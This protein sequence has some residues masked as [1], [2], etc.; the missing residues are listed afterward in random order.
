MRIER[1][2]IEGFGPFASRQEIDFA[3]L[4]EAGLFLITGRTGS[5][6][7]SIL[8]A[9]CFALYGTAPRYDG[10]QARL[11]SDAAADSTPTRVTLEFAVGEDR[12]RVVRSPEYERPKQR[13]SGTTRAAQTATLERWD[14]RGADWVGVAAR[15]VDVAEHLGPVL[16]LTREQFLQVILLAQGRFQEF[17]RAK[18]DERLG[19]LRALFGT[20]RFQRFEA[21][22]T[23]RARVL[24]QA[25][26]TRAATLRAEV[27]R[28][29]ELGDGSADEAPEQDVDIRRG[30]HAARDDVAV[31]VLRAVL[32]LE[33]LVHAARSGGEIEHPRDARRAVGVQHVGMR[34]VEARVGEPDERA[35]SVGAERVVCLRRADEEADAI[36]QEVE[37]RRHLE[38]HV[39]MHRR[40]LANEVRRPAKTRDA[41][42][43]FA[44]AKV[45]RELPFR[46]RD[47]R[48]DLAARRREDLRRVRAKRIEKRC[49]DR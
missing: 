22:V 43:D 26:A 23:E 27:A 21:E 32:V 5:G 34:D 35:R 40:E 44:Q 25:V 14:A 11:R 10:A 3:P 7:S 30:E 12:W 4:D 1:L 46:D 47:E 9:I 29:I 42:R 45:A 2:V 48:A 17:L 33:V 38:V 20:D 24:E 37:R 39:G 36:V 18:S 49:P 15:P 31:R 6:K 8:D 16:Q 19:L 41:R 28:L 13:G